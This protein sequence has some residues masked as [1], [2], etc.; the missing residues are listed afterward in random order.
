MHHIEW[1]DPHQNESLPAYSNRLSDGIVENGSQIVLIGH[2]MGGM[3]AQEIA[4]QKNIAL[5]ILISSIRSKREIPPFFRMIRLLKLYHLF[6]KKQ[7]IKT[8]K[9]WGK[10]HGFERVKD[11]EFFKSMV[12]RHSNHYLQWALKNLSAWRPPEPPINT[13]VY[14]I[15]GAKDRTFPIRHITDPDV[16][17]DLGGH[18]ML[19]HKSTQI[20]DILNH[21]LEIL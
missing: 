4:S 17:L 8:V 12:K 7:C 11:Q 13:K 6:S 5:I 2:S 14:Q 20:S 21:E 9:Y 10:Y 18:L 3:I 16:I 19:Y 15:H 1:V